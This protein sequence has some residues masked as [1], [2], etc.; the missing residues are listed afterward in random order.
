[1][2][3]VATNGD[4]EALAIVSSVLYVGGHFT[5]VGASDRD[6]L[7]ALNAAGALQAWDPGADGVFRAFG[8]AITS[9]RVAFGGEF[10]QVSGDAHQGVVQ[11]AGAA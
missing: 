10:T 4:V 9:G 6:H 5:T 2:W 3:D 7:A 1:V 8:A 11:F